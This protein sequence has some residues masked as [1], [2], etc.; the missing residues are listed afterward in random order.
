VT[1]NLR[2]FIAIELPG[3]VLSALNR[4]QHDLQRDPALAPLRWARPEGI[5]LT[6]KFLGET[7]ADRRPEIEAAISGAAAG[8]RPFQLHLGKAG[9][10]GGRNA[11]RV[12]WIDVG[13]ETVALSRLQAQIEHG[14]SPLGYPGENRT[15]SPHLTLARVPPERA[16]EV[17]GP[18]E[19]ALSRVVVPTASM[20]VEV[21]S[22]MRS[23]LQRGGAVYTQLFAARL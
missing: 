5:H 15:F 9:R 22:L 21:V 2:L 18:L 11:P 23:E 6:L 4:V 1:V 19:E 8:V 3:N 16:R 10:F 7:P 20:Q 17:A 12:V 13:G 14:V